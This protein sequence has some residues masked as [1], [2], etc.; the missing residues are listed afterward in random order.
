MADTWKVTIDGYKGDDLHVSVCVADPSVPPGAIASLI[1]AAP[2]MLDALEGLLN[3]EPPLLS[4]KEK[5]AYAIARNAIAK[6]RE[7]LD[8]LDYFKRRLA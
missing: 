7:T 8:I 6:A 2:E 3:L 4:A 1:A 5:K